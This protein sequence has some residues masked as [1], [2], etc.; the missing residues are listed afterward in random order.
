MGN[1]SLR[2]FFCSASADYIANCLERGIESNVYAPEKV[3]ENIKQTVC[4]ERRRALLGKDEARRMFNETD[5]L[6]LHDDPW[7]EAS[8]MQ[9]LL[10][11]EW[12]YRLP[13]KPNP[14][15]QYLCRIITA[16]QQALAAD[17]VVPV[18]QP[19]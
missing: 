4:A 19:A 2:E 5:D 7:T 1:E 12:W 10:G 13:T 6:T 8:L 18:A 16:I 14:D 3:K 15:Y 17:L 9:D 11:N